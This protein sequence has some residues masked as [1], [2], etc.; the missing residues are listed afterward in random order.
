[1]IYDN[2]MKCKQKNNG[3]LRMDRFAAIFPEGDAA[4][5]DRKDFIHMMIYQVIRNYVFS[6]GL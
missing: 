2:I 1:M 6:G 5:L 4:C 3:I